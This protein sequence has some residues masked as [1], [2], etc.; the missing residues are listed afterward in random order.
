MNAVHHSDFGTA[1]S[2]GATQRL[3]RLAKLAAIIADPINHFHPDHVTAFGLDQDHLTALAK[4]NPIAKRLNAALARKIGVDRLDLGQCATGSDNMFDLVIAPP[5]QFRSFLLEVTAVRLQKA[6][7]NC[8][9]KA[10]REK[11]RHLLGDTAYETA[12]REAPFFYTDL[13]AAIDTYS[14]D[15]SADSLMGEGAA[16]THSYMSSVDPGLAQIFAWRLPA[17]NLSDPVELSDSQ[18][19][20]FAK[21]LAAK[22]PAKVRTPK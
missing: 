12:L 10:D 11:V 16:L 9:L 22:T 21:L 4:A 18:R 13:A 5:M 20:S 2:G 19:S 1:M 6:I 7:R 3:T 8:V 14:F 15:V 17:D